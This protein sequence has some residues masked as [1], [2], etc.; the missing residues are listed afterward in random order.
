MKKSP[1]AHVRLEVA[2]PDEITARGEGATLRAGIAKT[3]FGH[4]LLGE[5]PR[6]ICH[7]SLFDEDDAAQSI[8]EM[9]AVWPQAK[10][11]WDHSRAAD[12]IGRIFA[13]ADSSEWSVYV[14]GTSFQV[15]V[16]NALLS[17]PVGECIGYGKLAAAVG[18]S[19][20]SRAVGSA[21]GKNEV[22]FLVPCHR[23]I[24]ADG[25]C[26]NYRWGPQRKRA[27][28]EW[29]KADSLVAKLT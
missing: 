14:R 22:S 20:A 24:L 5:M 16:W 2:T 11:V 28:L 17:I 19:K 12:L 10:L 27:M 8:I 1:I 21:V 13:R 23:V 3:A 26:G 25:T 9:Q 18:K 4:C 6:G 15:S 7:M 29:E